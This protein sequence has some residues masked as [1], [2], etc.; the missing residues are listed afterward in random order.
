Y[1]VGRPQTIVVELVGKL[2]PDEHVVRIV[3]NMCIY[4]DQVLV[5]AATGAMSPEIHLAPESATLRW[6]GFSA[7]GGSVGRTNLDYDYSSVS[8]TYPWK[9]MP[10]RYTRE[11][12]VRELLLSSDDR[13]VVC[14]P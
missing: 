7:P 10:G 1:P 14:R 2:R 13:L 11:G 8:T 3:S 4:W 5:S 6:R 9:M 12:D